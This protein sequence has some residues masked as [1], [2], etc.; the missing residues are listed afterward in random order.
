MIC[1]VYARK[2]TDQNGVADEA[3]SVARQIEHSRAYADRKGWAVAEEYVLPTM[4]CPARS[5]ARN[6]RGWPGY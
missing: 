1:A 5:S 6:A 2:S 3:K 4:A